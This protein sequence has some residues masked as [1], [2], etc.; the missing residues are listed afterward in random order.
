MS[1]IHN[2]DNTCTQNQFGQ[3]SSEDSKTLHRWH[4]PDSLDFHVDFVPVTPC[5]LE[6]DAKLNSRSNLFSVLELSVSHLL[7]FHCCHCNCLSW[8]RTCTASCFC[9]TFHFHLSWCLVL[10]MMVDK[11]LYCCLEA[12]VLENV[13]GSTKDTF[14]EKRGW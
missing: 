4:L 14:K 11:H 10:Q 9:Q 7:H 6:S 3:V 13:V 1:I 8:M 5:C 2:T 12:L